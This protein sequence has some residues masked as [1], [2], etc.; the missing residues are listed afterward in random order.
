MDLARGE[1]LG[2]SAGMGALGRR[3]YLTLMFSDLSGSTPLGAH[4]EAE[5][6]ADMLGQLRGLFHAIIPKHRGLIARIQGDGV[7]VIFGYPQAGEDDGRCATE[8]ALDLHE[9]ASR[10][11][12]PGLPDYV[13]H[14]SL[15]TGIHGGLVY[16]AS[17]DVERGRFELVGDVPNTAARL[18][19]LAR[20]GEI[21]VSEETLGAE[22]NFFATSP[23]QSV[24]LRGKS[25]ALAVYQVLGRAAVQNRFQAR[26]MRGLAPFVGRDEERRLLG[27]LLRLAMAGEPQCVA[28]S[29]GP[30]LGK[31]R[32][33]EALVADAKS[34]GCQ[35]LRGYCESYLGAEPLQPFL[36][37]LR[38]LLGL[39]PGMTGAQAL[40]SAEAAFKALPELAEAQQATLL[41]ASSLQGEPGARPSTTVKIIAA[42]SGFINALAQRGPLLLIVDDLQWADDA[43]QQMLD[44][45]RASSG[46]LFVVMASRPMAADSMP[47]RKIQTI[48]L[49]PLSQDEAATSIAHLLPG[50]DP[51]IVAEIHGYAGGN[52][53]FVEELCHAANANANA[54]NGYR[55]PL[56]NRLSGAAWLN[57]LIE[58]RFARLAPDQAEIVR[59]A[60]VIGNVVPAWLLTRITGHAQDA[61]QLQALAEQDFIYPAELFGTL[62]FKHGITRD[63]VYAALGLHQ[64][65]AMHLAV[66][67]A[68]CDNADTSVSDDGHEELAY[69]FGAAGVAQQAAHFAEL[70]GD[71]AMA[72]QALDRARALYLATLT[73]LDAMAPL[74]REGQLRWCAVAEKLGMACVFDPLGLADGVSIF[75]RGVALARQTGDI[76]AMARAEY[77]MGYICYAKGLALAAT[78]HCEAS[79]ALAMQ[80]GDERLA[81]Q[82]RATLAQVLTSA[83]EYGRAAE[84]F[85]VSL[86]SKR[87]Q[88]KPGSSVAI[89]SAFALSCKGCL[90]GDQGLFTQAQDC[91]T[92]ALALLGDSQHSVG[93][94]V[95]GW[96]AAVYMWQGRWEDAIVVARH[97]AGIAQ[98][99]RSRQLLAMSRALAGYAD[100]VLTARV[101][102]LQAVRE[103]TTW[104]EERNGAYL[105]SLNYGW[106]VDGNL[107]QGHVEEARRYAARLLMRARQQ[108]RIGEA[109]GCRALALAASTSGHFAQA[110]HYLALAA[111]SATARNSAHEHAANQLCQAHIEVL[112]GSARDAKPWLDSACEGF[113]RMQMQWHLGQAAQLRMQT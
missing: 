91:F 109:M 103:A 111:K 80:L 21:Y 82:V 102:S 53:L 95:R 1:P 75:E 93:S 40:D 8:A 66:A 106:L 72:A 31:T 20:A 61:P 3:R 11:Q 56:E 79:L 86:S 5:D 29:A 46:P 94:A 55:K 97:S 32:L 70:G 27:K 44:V 2:T 19:D 4:M 63:V 35:V 13:Q 84:L 64:R 99:T 37:I 90:L 38:S 57:A 23:R 101:E 104:I 33:I 85:D 15:H 71:R 77:W 108:D 24:V 81:A 54:T 10:L 6:Y 7:L 73:A 14:I 69:H 65:K 22:A 12:V 105:T 48:E 60:A 88:S 87:Q 58:S 52:P 113:E 67:N 74:N 96:I 28:V 50:A 45:I 47:L 110:S 36:Q 9:A 92:E 26:S 98:H 68:L 39:Q 51:F 107:A 83:C 16:L 34:Q 89:G 25:S 30:G 100:W 49:Q 76:N 78:L 42:M 43:S 17:G 41:Q 59:A 62:R 18:S 112:R